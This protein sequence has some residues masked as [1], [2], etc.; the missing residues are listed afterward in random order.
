MPKRYSSNYH[1][2]FDS[3]KARLSSLKAKNGGNY[4]S[5][6]PSTSRLQKTRKASKDISAPEVEEQNVEYEL[7]LI[8][9]KE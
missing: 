9:R 5:N 8:E 3:L 1:A 2:D 4:D 7:T 6:I